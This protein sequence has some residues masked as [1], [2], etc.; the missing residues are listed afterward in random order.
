MVVATEHSTGRRFVLLETLRE[1]AGR[2]LEE[3][4]DQSAVRRR[5]LDHFR[6]FFHRANAEVRGRDELAAHLSILA[7][8][9]NLRVALATACAFD[10]GPAAC[11]LINDVHWWAVTR[12]RAEVGEW[13]E[14]VHQLP[15]TADL[16]ARTAATAG[17]AFFAY[18]RGDLDTARALI[19]IARSEE[20]RFGEFTEPWVPAVEMF[21]VTDQFAMTIETQRR[22]RQHGDKFWETVG[23]LQET[24]LRSHYISHF[25]LA[26]DKL[27]RNLARINEAVDMAERLGNPNCIAYGARNLGGAIW[28]SD[29]DRAQLLLE[30][31]LAT[32]V[33][34]GLE[35][36]AGQ[37]RGLLAGLHTSRRRP[38]T[39]LRI[40]TSALQA[41]IRAG[42]MS[43]LA[44]DL[45]PCAHAF[46][47]V[48]HLQLAKLIVVAVRAADADLDTAFA[49]TALDS[50]ITSLLA[51]APGEHDGVT[52]KA[53][54]LVEIAG[55]VIEAVDESSLDD[56]DAD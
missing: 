22:A 7:E 5:H 39:A 14:W 9:H 32:A 30:R 12:M 11:D 8:W 43:E 35:L 38:W 18:M 49:L 48:G 51:T 31:A 24:I 40:M 10:D 34:L 27:A 6:T 13:S 45:A 37:T 28:K 29:P 17:A 20:Q 50:H 36:L 47:A 33:P 23:I 56:S 21:V 1:F 15:A 44:V 2:R 4:G 42:A 53:V 3:R 26:P 54:D 46:V 19:A 52:T 25:D 41:H 16:P 55:K